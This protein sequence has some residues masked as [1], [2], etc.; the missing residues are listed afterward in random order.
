MFV[1]FHK[2]FKLH[3]AVLLSLFNTGPQT[4][5]TENV[6]N[7]QIYSS[8]INI[9]TVLAHQIDTVLLYKNKQTLI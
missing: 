9:V 6:L 8:F 1:E 2:K 4:I 5:H 7:I 3:G